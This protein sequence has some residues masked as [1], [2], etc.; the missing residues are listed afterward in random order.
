MHDLPT[1]LE[2]HPYGDLEIQLPILAQEALDD[3]TNNEK[4]NDLRHTVTQPGDIERR[5]M[6][7]RRGTHTQLSR[8][9]RK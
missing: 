6:S 3:P 5:T 4:V 2:A 7:S 1:I 8:T 9:L